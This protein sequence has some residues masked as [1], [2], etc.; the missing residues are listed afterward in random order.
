MSS[1]YLA[2]GSEPSH[3][4]SPLLG[5]LSGLPPIL[6]QVGTAE[7]MLDDSKRFVEKAKKAKV[8]I[9][10][11][12]WEDMFHGWHGNAHILKDAEQAIQNIGV[13]CKNLY[14]K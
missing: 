3:L 1:L 11:E 6:V 13:F 10:I 7:T 4:A 9:Q 5:N 2:N 12:V 14:N 8:D